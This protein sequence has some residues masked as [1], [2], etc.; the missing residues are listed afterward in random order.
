[1]NSL[2]VEGAGFEHETN[3]ISILNKAGD[4]KDFPLL[5]KF[6]AANNILSE[7]LQLYKS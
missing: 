2:Q 4:Q 7:I 5:S 6:Q 1:M 3:K